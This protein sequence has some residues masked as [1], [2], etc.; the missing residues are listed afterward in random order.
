MA[1]VQP[2]LLTANSTKSASL[3]F[4]RM[5]L[6]LLHAGL[7]DPDMAC[8]AVAASIITDTVLPVLGFY[9]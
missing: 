3:A 7:F 9:C 1:V 2:I 4:G 6:P 5:V 8:V